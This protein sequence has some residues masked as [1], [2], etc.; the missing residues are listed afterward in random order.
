LTPYLSGFSLAFCEPRASRKFAPRL[1]EPAKPPQNS[2]GSLEKLARL[3]KEIS[4]Q[5]DPDKK[6]PFW[7]GCS[8]RPHVMLALPRSKKRTLWQRLTGAK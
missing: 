1:R 2:E 7:S 5:I 4:E 3:A 6:L 8:N